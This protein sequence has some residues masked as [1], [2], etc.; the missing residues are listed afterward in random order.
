MILCFIASF[1]TIPKT[2][3]GTPL[4]PVVIIALDNPVEYAQVGPEDLGVVEFRGTV[5]ATFSSSTSIIVTLSAKDTW[6][7]ADVAHRRYHFQVV[8]IVPKHSLSPSTYPTA[9]AWTPLVM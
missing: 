4:E 2:C 9:P 8:I 6:N 5:T 1:I 7:N 3:N